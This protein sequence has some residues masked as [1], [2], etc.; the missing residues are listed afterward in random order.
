MAP[1]TE[2]T[3]IE[4]LSKYGSHP[5]IDNSAQTTLV[6]RC[7]H[8][9]VKFWRILIYRW[10]WWEVASLILSINAMAAVLWIL[11]KI[12][13]LPLDQWT[14]P[15]QANSLVSVFLTISKSALLIP[16][17]ECISQAKWMQF[18]RKPQKLS[19]LQEYDDASRGPFGAAVLLVRKVGWIAWLGAFLSVIALALDPFVQQIIEFP[20]RPVALSSGG[21][22]ISATQSINKIDLPAMRGAILS[23]IYSPK[24]DP[25]SPL[26]YTCTTGSCLW[27]QTITSVGVCS[28]CHDMTSSFKP[29]C[30]TGPG[31]LQPGPENPD[32]T[33]SSSTTTCVY[34][35]DA[36]ANVTLTAFIQTIAFPGA[37]GRPAEYASQ[38][39][40]LRIDSQSGLGGNRGLKPLALSRFLDPRVRWVSTALTY[41]T[42]Y[43]KD[44]RRMPNLTIQD[45]APE[46]NL[47][48]MYLCAQTYD[49]SLA[50][51][52]GSLVNTEPT[53]TLALGNIFADDGRAEFVPIP[54]GQQAEVLVPL[55]NSTV[56]NYGNFTSSNAS[57]AADP[58][59]NPISSSS[60]GQNNKTTATS[61]IQTT[62]RFT[63]SQQA[64]FTLHGRLRR[65]I[66]NIS[67]S[68]GNIDFGPAFPEP[69]YGADVSALEASQPSSKNA[70]SSQS[71]GATFVNVSATFG[72][73]ARGITARLLVENGSRLVKGDALHEETFFRVAWGWVVLPVGVVVLAVGLLG[74]T[75]W[76]SSSSSF[77]SLNG[78]D[79]QG[80][81]GN[82]EERAGDTNSSS[83]EDL[84]MGGHEKEGGTN[85]G[86]TLTVEDMD[87][88]SPAAQTEVRR[89]GRNGQK[90]GNGKPG[91][92]K[93]SSLALLISSLEMRDVNGNVSRSSLQEELS[94]IKN[95][96]DLERFADTKMVRLAEADLGGGDDASSKG[97]RF[98]IVGKC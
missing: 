78:S 73:L 24:E 16:V 3:D 80:G 88:K 74:G 65:E 25:S 87:N 79:G 18:S 98:V 77:S 31:P 95:L 92:W 1:N 4:S 59:N 30:T 40:Q 89:A 56:I 91:I 67:Q 50:V 27:N 28:F 97:R 75:I 86:T 10:W 52:N 34:T 33:W 29:E 11:C 71:D 81:N 90:I 69:N 63:I 96:D 68:S 45:L 62:G 17:A 23:A 37:Y 85:G 21:A 20:S 48:A 41:T 72:R 5:G 35:I 70:Y 43:D 9:L 26:T 61:A 39:T 32:Q 94:H 7:W 83:S 38:Y 51:V 42:S 6:S 8:L 12:N 47:C 54:D 46:I 57:S 14:F 13:G 58:S 55:P 93:G 64:I 76:A 49:R 53:S 36:A 82:N 19:R 66:L 84:G 2:D 15:I 60:A 22:Q 44:T